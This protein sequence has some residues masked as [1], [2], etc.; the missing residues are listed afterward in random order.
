MLKVN[1]NIKYMFRTDA[2]ILKQRLF[3]LN[4]IFYL[5]TLG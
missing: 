2:V 3:F 1:I 4:V 5:A